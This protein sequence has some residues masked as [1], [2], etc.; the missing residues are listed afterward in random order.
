VG[1]LLD[2]AQH[3]LMARAWPSAPSPAA[4]EMAA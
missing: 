4:R 1:P 2:T 3:L